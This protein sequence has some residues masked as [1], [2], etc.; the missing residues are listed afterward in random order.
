MSK[1][2]NF[3]INPKKLSE[4]C[5]IRELQN[6]NFN[7][8]TLQ[9]KNIEKQLL[10]RKSNRPDY[11]NFFSEAQKTKLPKGL[12]NGRWSNS[13]HKAFVDGIFNFSNDWKKITDHIKT[14]NCPQARSHSQK[15]FAKLNK[16][17]TKSNV[18]YYVDLKKIFVFG[19]EISHEKKDSVSEMLVLAHDHLD[20]VLNCEVLNHGLLAELLEISRKNKLP[21]G[22][23]KE[24]E[25]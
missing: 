24:K 4:L 17:I 16:Y 11:K 6:E 18:N 9:E 13:E 20:N 1:T 5:N 22:K 12:N 7:L 10:L 25:K 3:S 2:T 14:R 19:K 8:K 23:E 21:K 15:F